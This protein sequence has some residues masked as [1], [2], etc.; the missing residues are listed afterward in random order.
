M[1]TF[2]ERL[3]WVLV[4][5]LWQFALLSAVAFVLQRV[6]RR[7][8]ASARY[9]V[10]LTMLGIIVTAPF[11]TWEVLP[12]EAP[13]P[14]IAVVFP[15]AQPNSVAVPEVVPLLAPVFPAPVAPVVVTTP[16]AT[17]P[18]PE[19]PQPTWSKRIQEAVTPWLST[20]VWGWSLGVL[21]FA[22][23]PLLSWFTVH[24]LR[25]TGVSPVPE[26]VQAALAAT[27][28]RLGITQAVLVLQS[29]VV[30]VPIVAGYF[31]PV[32]LLPVSI[33]TGLPASQLEA[34]LAHEL[35]H[36]RRH[37]YLVNLIQT[38]VETVCFYHPAV[39]W[40]SHQIRCER[41]NCCDDIAVSVIGN[42]VDYSRALLALEELRAT[43][44][45][46]ALGASGGSLLS[47]VRRLFA[48]E[49]APSH[50]SNGSVALGATLVVGILTLAAITAAGPNERTD[51]K[52]TESDMPPPTLIAKLPGGLEVEL[53]GVTKNFA[54]TK[55]GWKPDGSPIGE[56]T[57]WPTR[58]I[59]NRHSVKTSRTDD[60]TSDP[61][62]RDLLVEMRGLQSQPAFAFL[63][64]QAT[65]GMSHF[66]LA[67]PY[68]NRLSLLLNTPSDTV[69]F[70]MAMS[71]APWGPYQQVGLDG[72]LLNEMDL[73]EPEA[74]HYGEIRVVRCGPHPDDPAQSELTLEMP[75][76]YQ[77]QYTWEIHAIDTEGKE[78][79]DRSSIENDNSGKVT[80]KYR[81]DSRL[82]GKIARWE[83]RLRPYRHFITFENVSLEPGKKTVPKVSVEPIAV[84]EST[85]KA[86]PAAKAI[87]QMVES[88][89]THYNG[90]DVVQAHIGYT[91]PLREGW[92][93][94]LEKDATASL[95]KLPAGKHWLIARHP[96]TVFPVELPLASSPLKQQPRAGVPPQKHSSNQY[97]GELKVEVDKAG[98]EFIRVNVR[99]MTD[100]AWSF[101]ELDLTL[102]AGWGGEES[103]GHSPLWVT[104]KLDEAPRI[105]IAAR[106]TGSFRIDWA[107][108]VRRGVWDPMS[109]NQEQDRPT[110]PER[111]PGKVWV[112]IGGP[113]F[114]TLPVAVTHPDKWLAD[115]GSSQIKATLPGG[116]EL[117]LLGVT[118][119]RGSG[120]E[121]WTPQGVKFEKAP[122]WAAGLKVNP[123]PPGGQS[124][125]GDNDFRDFI[126]RV[127]GFTKEQRALLPFSGPTIE[128]G[129]STIGRMSVLTWNQQ[130]QRL[131]I[132]IPGEWGPYRVLTIDPKVPPKAKAVEVPAEVPV[133]YR[134]VYDSIQPKLETSDA[135]DA[136]W[137]MIQSFPPDY[138]PTEPDSEKPANYTRV[139]WKGQPANPDLKY[140]TIETV[141]VDLQ[142][143][144]HTT[145]GTTNVQD[146]KSQWDVDLFRVSF[147][148]VSHVEYRLR[149]Y[150]H[151]VTFN[152]VALH[153]GAKCGP[154]VVVESIAMAD[155]RH[156]ESLR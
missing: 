103:E 95:E 152:N 50:L 130:V 38:L 151:V 55:D 45:P 27:A 65:M 80:A 136:F 9:V 14:V 28:Q 153:V 68:R 138:R 3:G 5:S 102:G 94:W 39:W 25:T 140:T 113:G 91:P 101:S 44:T 52:T 20:I 127:H 22:L 123:L 24:R 58:I 60:G 125:W 57:E 49:P 32:I 6:M 126:V 35:A 128:S 106:Q 53:V 114:G 105:E 66:P 18:L 81:T 93:N 37:D 61:A 135:G 90:G 15:P 12:V 63:D 148:Q 146:G 16:V 121:G 40:L 11:A 129:D 156:R 144:R 8:S 10:L 33:V 99:N 131:R 87:L 67:N 41:E 120:V 116:L 137:Q 7:T 82:P 117:E 92:M 139:V 75:E 77:D 124:D 104:E 51:N 145:T 36:I 150:Q 76:K 47:R 56:T 132:G 13:Q 108:W 141:L 100:E 1:S 29:V 149:P 73:A 74:G 122:E 34:I 88:A 2:M 109:G 83:Y 134:K 143:K 118:L 111:Q 96:W 107:D 46:L 147:D 119:Y 54:P 89:G 30:Q 97:S 84:P 42:R 115:A 72:K 43:Q 98:K 69:T 19:L 64:L 23:R 79:F 85:S 86:P 59:V 112:R 78:M 4:H 21:A 17:A 142:G 133:P 71:D 110:L 26:T 70:R 154:N 48:R 31:K 62:A 155:H